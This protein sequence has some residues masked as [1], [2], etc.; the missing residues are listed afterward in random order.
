MTRTARASTVVEAPA[1][2]TPTT[3][4]LTANDWVPNNPDLPVLHYRHVIPSGSTEERA[5]QLEALFERNGWPPQWRN[6]IYSYH[7]YHTEGHE[8]LGLAAG[9]ARVMLG[10]PDGDIVDLRAGDVV[11]L[12]AGIGHCLVEASEDYLV[13]GAYPPGQD[14]DTCRAAPSAAMRERI[15]TLPYPASDPVSGA[16]GA[17]PAIWNA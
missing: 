8:V 10:G 15:R 11:V 1:P 7:H 12:P 16:D 13:V 14:A 5:S 3:L 17:L 2:A 9:R 4:L 6:G